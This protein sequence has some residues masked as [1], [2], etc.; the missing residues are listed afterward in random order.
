MK[1]ENRERGG[2]LG[3]MNGLITSLGYNPQIF[4]VPSLDCFVWC[5]LIF[6]LNFL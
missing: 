1:E 4:R 2:I 6:S 3:G 5:Y